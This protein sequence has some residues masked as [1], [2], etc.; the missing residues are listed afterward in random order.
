MRT[1]LQDLRY[2]VRVF[3]KSPG[4]TLAAVLAVALGVG[5]NTTVF[6]FVNAI[7]LRPIVGVSDPERLAEVY[8]SDYS[9]GLYGATSYPDYVDFRDQTDAFEGLA[10][11]QETVASFTAAGDDVPERARGV[12]VTGNYFDVLGVKPAAGRLFKPQDDERAGAHPLVVISHDL[13]RRRF[14]SNAGIV[15]SP[16]SLDSLPYTVVG[17]AAQSYHGMRLGE[18]AP[19]FWIPMAQMPERDLTS[20]G[21]RGLELIGRL[22]AGATPEGAQGQL[23]SVAAR[24]AAAYPDTNRG[25][26]ERPNEAR[27]ISVEPAA[28]VGPGARKTLRAVSGLLLAVVGLVLL[29]ACANVANLLLA[30]ASTRRR[31]IAIRLALGASRA[32][33]VRQLITESLALSLAGGAVGLVISLWTADLLPGFFPAEETALLDLSVDSRVLIFTLGVSLLTGFVFGLAPA[34]HSSRP[35]LVSALK[36]DSSGALAGLRRFGLRN[37]LVI[38]QVA[39]SLVLLVAAGLFLRSLRNAVNFDPGF[40]SN[41]LLLASLEMRGRELTK[42]QGAQLYAQLQERVSHLPGVRAAS[43]TRVTPISG[44]GQ[45]RGTTIEG[46]QPRPNEDTEL[47]TNVIGLNFFQTMGIPVVAGRDFDARDTAKSQPVVVVNE[48]FARRYYGGQSAVGRRLRTDSE[49]PFAEIVGVARDAKYRDL[50][51]RPLPFIYIP[52]GQEYQQGMTLAVRTEGDPLSVAPAVR[53]VMQQLN[54]SLPLYNV[55]T[56]RSHVRAALAVDRMFAVL[57]G[58]FGGAAL[59][60]AGV[61]VYG[62]MSYAVAHRTREIG[63]RMALGAKPRDVLRLVVGQGMTLILIGGAIGLALAFALSRVVSGLLF[64]LSAT[65]P[66]TFAGVTL[67]LGSAALLACYLPARRAAKVDPMIALRHE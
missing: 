50:R 14:D 7:L 37:A 54:K 53:S 63:I 40:D 51:E 29:I 21:S 1:V 56:M 23:Q 16:V 30:R 44:G 42:E 39:L 64:N 2:A 36:D 46:Y 41:N 28:L 55:K 19:D 18:S 52:M 65:D 25:T 59:L 13:W 22:K 27:P 5:A 17:V 57:L 67:L 34:I 47:N 24:L 49:G 31:E 58:V 33:L 35:D 20:R 10:A 3:L 12:Y 32:R 6:S 43:F 60:L 45:R 62:V 15:G 26:L 66:L 61:G 4:F 8:T 11:Y 38:A 48:E 9:S